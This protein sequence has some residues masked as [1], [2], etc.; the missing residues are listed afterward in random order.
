MECLSFFPTISSTVCL[1]KQH[2]FVDKLTLLFLKDVRN[3]SLFILLI[4]ICKRF[5][6]LLITI[7]FIWSRILKTNMRNITSRNLYLVISLNKILKIKL[8]F[9]SLIMIKTYKS[10]CN[11]LTIVLEKYSMKVTITTWKGNGRLVFSF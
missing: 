2:V 5:N 6:R 4:V 11:T 7:L 9:C 10:Y 8:T 3:R 1:R